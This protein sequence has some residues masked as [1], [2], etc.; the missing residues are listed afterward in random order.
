MENG[1]QYGREESRG[2]MC[3][4][5]GMQ[6]HILLPEQH[7]HWHFTVNTGEFIAR[8]TP[9]EHYAIVLSDGKPYA[10]ADM[11]FS[12]LGMHSKVA[13]PY[14]LLFEA[15]RLSARATASPFIAC[16]EYPVRV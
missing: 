7:L 12:A 15:S 8:T 10:Y 6:C 2:G 16:N 9:G 13:I 11:L 5:V 4:R 3:Q 1:W 14:F